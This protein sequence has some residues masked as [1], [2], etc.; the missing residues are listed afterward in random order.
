MCRRWG[1]GMLSGAGD[2]I[3]IWSHVDM[4]VLYQGRNTQMS[5]F[6]M[7]TPGR[8]QSPA[9]SFGRL[10]TQVRLS[11]FNPF[12]GKRQPY[13]PR[14][15]E[16]QVV[17]VARGATLPSHSFPTARWQILSTTSRSTLEAVRRHSSAK[18]SFHTLADLSWQF[19]LW[20]TRFLGCG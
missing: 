10:L 6:S 20:T 3:A 2:D 15:V 9:V 16:F 5:L 13:K 7:S 12:Q 1:G 19:L 14:Q 11:I 18:L 17:L 4:L 8:E